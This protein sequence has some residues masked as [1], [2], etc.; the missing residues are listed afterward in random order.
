MP[1]FK[2]LL[3]LDRDQIVDYV[4][5]GSSFGPLAAYPEM[6]NKDSALLDP[7][8][9]YSISTA[10]LFLGNFEAFCLMTPELTPNDGTLHLAALLALPKFVK[11][12]LGTHEPDY[13]A[14]EFDN[15]VPL[16][17]ACGSR[18]QPWCK[19]ANEES[20]WMTRQKE[21]MQLLAPRTSPEWR[22][23]NMTILH[24][25]MDNGLDT[26]KAM[27][28]ALEIYNDAE[29]DDKYLYEDR[30]GIEYSPQQY[31]MKDLG[32]GTMEKT[33]L[34]K[35]LHSTG[36]KSRYFKRI[37]PIKGEQPKGYHGLPTRY[38]RVWEL[39]EESPLPAN[40]AYQE[41]LLNFETRL[42]PGCWDP[43]WP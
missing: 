16:A 26:A 10:S 11:W 27:I 22:L 28:E 15:M 31:V 8:Q 43:W 29:K 14:E 33:A 23:R 36:L 32:A 7:A 5:P 40:E 35:C 17:C 9:E 30:D 1:I 19:I 12:L 13:K 39:H 37:L 42:M 18:P 21:T 4:I 3:K 24:W 41:E 20:D 6:F 38:A 25:A 2:A 34:I